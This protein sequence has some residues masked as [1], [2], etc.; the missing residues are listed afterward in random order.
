MYV[1]MYVYIYMYMSVC[2]YVCSHLCACFTYKY[3]DMQLFILY[4]QAEMS[5]CWIIMC[6][7]YCTLTAIGPNRE[8]STQKRKRS[9]Q[10]P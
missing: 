10:P 1:C 7:I 3:I 2:M 6:Q 4:G 9:N 5:L 8:I